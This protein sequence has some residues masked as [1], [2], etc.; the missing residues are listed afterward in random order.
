MHLKFLTSGQFSRSEVKVKGKNRHMCSDLKVSLLE[1][2]RLHQTGKIGCQTKEKN[3]RIPKKCSKSKVKVTLKIDLKLGT[4]SHILRANFQDVLKCFEAYQFP[5][6]GSSYDTR[7]LK[8]QGHRRV[9]LLEAI[10]LIKLV[11]MN[12]TIL[13]SGSSK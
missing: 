10:S 13:P 11:I 8:V 3:L 2:G 4:F 12:K 5:I 7:L 6:C 9:S 1:D